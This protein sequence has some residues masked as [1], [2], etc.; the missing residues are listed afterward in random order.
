[1]KEIIVMGSPLILRGGVARLTEKQARSRMLSLKPYLDKKGKQIKDCYE[2]IS[3]ICFKVG[4]VIGYS[5]N[6]DGFNPEIVAQIKTDEKEA[7]IA[8]LRAKIKEM[9][10]NA[11]KP[12]AI[13]NETTGAKRP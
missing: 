11:G 13:S 4:E 9:E 1:M 3:E 10:A 8:E 6:I 5:G 12:K 2:I 7:I